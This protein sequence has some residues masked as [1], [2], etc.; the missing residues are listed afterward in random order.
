MLT[1]LADLFDYALRHRGWRTTRG[2]I[3]SPY[4][5]AG[6]IEI[7]CGNTVYLVTIQRLRDA[8]VLQDYS[9]PHPR[10][11]SSFAETRSRE[12]GC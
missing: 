1:V 6:N 10:P 9:L 2:L 8:V 5:N 11:L 7:T 4:E 12:D 3:R